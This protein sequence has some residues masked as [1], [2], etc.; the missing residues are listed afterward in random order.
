MPD[1]TPLGH[2]IAAHHLFGW[3]SHCKGRT[4]AEEL[5]AW[6]V[7]AGKLPEVAEEIKRQQGR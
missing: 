6:Q 1:R 3:C 7:W 5:G 4:V 2:T